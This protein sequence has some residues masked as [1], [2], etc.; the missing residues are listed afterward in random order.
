[1]LL[2]PV[3]TAATRHSGSSAASSD[4]EEESM[5]S[6][7]ITEDSGND[8]SLYNRPRVGLFSAKSLP[9]PV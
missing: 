9:P 5:A 6:W 3:W 2:P 8:L 1:M 4:G 7:G